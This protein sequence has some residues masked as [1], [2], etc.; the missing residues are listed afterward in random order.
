MNQP[1]ISL[2]E[3]DEVARP[4]A[5]MRAAGFPRTHLYDAS[6]S[7]LLYGKFPATVHPKLPELPEA[8]RVPFNTVMAHRLDANQYGISR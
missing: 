8:T 5:P 6:S 7:N 4:D 2:H 1:H 3:F